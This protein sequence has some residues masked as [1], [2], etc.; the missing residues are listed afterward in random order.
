MCGRYVIARASA[1][2]VPLFE[3]TE[4]DENLPDPSYNIAPSQ[5]IP[6]VAESAKTPGR[7]LTPARWGL[8]PAFKKSPQDRPTPHNATVEKVP[9]SGMFRN[10]F[11]S[12]RAII[13]AEGF[14]ERRRE[15]HTSFYIHPGDDQALAF[16]GLYEWWKDPQKDE[17]D[18]S[19]WLLSATIITH[20]AQGKMTDIHHREPLYLAS[21]LYDDWLDPHTRGNQELLDAVMAA[22]TPVAESL[23][24]R[25]IGPGW[26]SSHPSSRRDD[27]DLLTPLSSHSTAAPA[28]D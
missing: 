15:D 17:D 23:E 25:T 27:A 12:R 20:P 7:R 10:A 24:F 16:A 14:Y 13:P 2:L 4:V 8:V 18:S 1:D 3:V 11:A 19:R 21:E 5:R 26:L 9:N 6:V 22:S 28:S